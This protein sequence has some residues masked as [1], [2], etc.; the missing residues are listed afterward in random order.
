MNG[1]YEKMR[2]DFKETRGIRGK[3]EEMEKERK[4]KG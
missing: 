4:K 2:M 3:R 1:R